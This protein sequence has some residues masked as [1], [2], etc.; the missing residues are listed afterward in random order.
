MSLAQTV[1]RQE[2]DLKVAGSN[3]GCGSV[4]Q[5]V[6]HRSS[7]PVVGGSSPPRTPRH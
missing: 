7:N 6:E 1:E 5:L 2:T 4:A 3:P